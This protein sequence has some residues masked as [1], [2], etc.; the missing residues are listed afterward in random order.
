MIRIVKVNSEYIKA[1]QEVDEFVYD[2]K[3]GSRPYIGFLI[4]VDNSLFVAPLTSPKPKHKTWSHKKKDI[5]LIDR[6][7]KGVLQLSNMIPVHMHLC[8][9]IN[10]DENSQYNNLLKSQFIDVD[11]NKAEVE[12][13]ARKLIELKENKPN[14]YLVKNCCDFGKLKN[15]CK[16]WK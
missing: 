15:I 1:L 4:D 16:T 12:K 2:N 7:N 11:N 3:S 6:G 5:Y 13:R 8:T 14:H 9:E 10:L